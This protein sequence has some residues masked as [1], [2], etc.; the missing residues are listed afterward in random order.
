M[1]NYITPDK[2]T[3][4]RRMWSLIRVLEFGDKPDSHGERVAICI[5]KWEDSPVLGMRWNGSEGSP[6]G[7][8]QSRGLPVWFI[9]PS[10]LQDAVIKTLSADN[11][12]LVNTLL[13]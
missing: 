10:R 1:E 3:S 6:I 5:G 12:R 8:P 13:R 4:P 11:Q 7:S 2:V 9:I